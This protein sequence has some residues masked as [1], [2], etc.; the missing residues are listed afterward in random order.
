MFSYLGRVSKKILRLMPNL[1]ASH[2]TMHR[3][4]PLKLP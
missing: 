1:A 4:Y 2:T 3:P